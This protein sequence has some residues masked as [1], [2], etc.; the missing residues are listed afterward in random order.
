MVEVLIVGAGPAGAAAAIVLARRGMRVLLVDRATFPRDKLCGDTVNPGAMAL[1]GRLGLAGPV[2]GSGLPLDGVRV[3][4]PR[5]VE[6]R[7]PYPVPL[8]GRAIR[9]RDLDA[10]LVAAADAA[11]AHVET[12]VR[13]V[14]PLLDTSGASPV[15]RGALL[16]RA[17]RRVRVPAAVVVAADGRRS[18]LA[19]AVGLTLVPAGPR[20]WAVGAYFSNVQGL[21]REGEMHV[22]A[23]HYVGIAPV[24]GGLAN[25]C[26]VTSDPRGLAAPGARLREALAMD[27]LLAERF[28]RARLEGAARS[29]GPLA[30]ESRAVGVPGLLLAGD[31]AGFVDPMTGDGVR[32]ALHGGLLAAEATLRLFD[33]PATDPLPWLADARRRAFGEKLRFDRALRALVPSAAGVRVGELL[34][35]F[36]PSLLRHIVRVAGDASLADPFDD[37]LARCLAPTT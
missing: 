19:S 21:G 11:G 4:S 14:G 25:V 28:A 34:A 18:A 6:V 3:T 12:G 10:L 7:G 31:A 15:V 33:Q 26:L 17:G 5:G 32:L 13:V 35:T 9:R 20:R 23:S 22:R 36:A 24:P 30:V 8:A 1:L 27:P 37:D 29:L 16:E 2:A